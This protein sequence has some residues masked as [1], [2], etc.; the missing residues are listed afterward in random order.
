MPDIHETL[1]TV[2]GYDAFRPRQ[3]EIVRAVLAGRDTLAL[4]PTGG[5]KSLCFQVPALA[6][7]KL[8]LVVSP[9][10]ALMKD[11]TER[12]RKL[13][14]RAASIT[15]GMDQHEVENTLNSAGLGK[16]DFLYVSPERL[17]TSIF[18]ARLPGLPLGLIAVDEAHC[19][20]QW[21]YDF[22]P[23]YLKIAEV[24]EKHPDV[25]VLA[26]TASATAMVADDIMLRLGFKAPHLVRGPF[27]RPEL[28]LWI[29]RGEDR[30]GRL[31]RIAR[32]TQGSGIIYL[33]QRKGTVR[34]AGLLKQHGISAA[35]YHAGLS[36][37]ERDAVQQQWMRGEIR[38]VAATNAFGMGIDKADVRTVVHMEPP[39]DLESYYQEAGRA[40]RDGT[41]AFAFLL[42]HES[43]EVAL[44]D[45]FATSFPTLAEVRRVYQAFA[46]QH[47]IALGSGEFETYDLDLR[48][49]AD[50][51]ALSPA[52][53]NH[54][55]KALELDGG[56]ALSEAVRTPSRV[57]IRATS[58][59]VYD[60]RVRDKRLGPVLEALQRM[61]GGLFEEPAIIDEERISR[62]LN[63]SVNQ[64]I[65]LLRDLHRR[66]VVFYRP[67]N[68]KPTVTLLVPRRDA[69][70]LTLDK[71]ALELR[72]E[73][74]RQRLEAMIHF[75]FGTD[76]CRERTL[77]G[78]FG[79]YTSG[80]CGHCDVCTSRT[81]HHKS[82][83][84]ESSP[85]P[86]PTSNGILEHRWAT[87]I[88]D[89]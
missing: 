67:R 81:D 61:Y 63:L 60:I 42:A 73:R 39:P 85:A 45:R 13:G 56:I 11:Q 70:K 21:G 24:R 79:E 40:G 6:M 16:L 76:Q 77:L 2:W 1:R 26:L 17:L 46:D 30:T 20:S 75:T 14:V 84:A 51:T 9:L 38:F 34:I 23:P 32:H 7:R 25:P 87:D 78:Y 88:N 82:V 31:L 12:L 33:R 3:E 5:G 71:E 43:D 62:H 8:C 86:L 10:I 44:R 18:Q 19:I 53:V 74:A 65:G 35:A 52:T 57:G 48:T 50:R 89:R 36:P 64:V 69:S 47:R 66:E 28:A 68:D 83:V 80:P 59:D 22:R 72:K 55:L 29:S 54:C 58:A 27:Q 37:E 4:L 15:S 41:A 49:I